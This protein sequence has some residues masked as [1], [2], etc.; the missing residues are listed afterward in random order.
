ME[1]PSLRIIRPIEELIKR[2]YAEN[3]LI[4]QADIPQAAPVVPFDMTDYKGFTGALYR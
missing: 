2:C 4:T 1:K 3:R